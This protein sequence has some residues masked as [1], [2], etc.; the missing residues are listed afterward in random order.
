MTDNA[1]IIDGCSVISIGAIEDT[2][3]T[4]IEVVDSTN[5]FALLTICRI[6]LTKDTGSVTGLTAEIG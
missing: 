2:L 4:V 3:I 5:I 6:S 1:S